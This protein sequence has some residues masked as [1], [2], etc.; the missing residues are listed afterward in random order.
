MEGEIVDLAKNDMNFDIKSFDDSILEIGDERKVK[1]EYQK[2]LKK[3]K[4]D[5]T[6]SDTRVA[7]KM[8]MIYMSKMKYKEAEEIFKKFRKDF[9]GTIKTSGK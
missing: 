8:G 3:K 2:I 7:I 5:I 4:K 6:I 1:R 9:Q